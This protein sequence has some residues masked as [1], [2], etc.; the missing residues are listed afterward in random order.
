MKRILLT[1]LLVLAAVPAWAADFGTTIVGRSTA[2]GPYSATDYVPLIRGGVVFKAPTNVFVTTTGIQTLSNKTLSSPVLT[3]PELGTP[4]SGTLTNASGLPLD[5]GVVG[6]LSV[7]NGGTGQTSYSNGEVL[8]GNSSTGGLSKATLTAGANVTITN[9]AGTITI[10]STGGGSGAGC[11]LTGSAGRIVINSG[12]STCVDT[13]IASVTVGALTLGTSGTLGSVTMGNATSGTLKIQPVTGALG[14]ATLSLPAATDTLVGRDTTDTLTN[15]TLTSP[16]INSPT[17]TSPVLGTV[18]SGNLAN[19]TGLPISTG[20]AGLGASVATFLGSA[21]SANL[22]TA[23]SDE[24][25]TGSLYFQSGDLGTP[26]AG[27][28]TNATGLPLTTGVTGTLPV[29]NGGSGQSS[30]TNGQLLIGNTAT[31]LLSKATLTAGTNITITNGN[32][33]ITID[34][35]GGGGSGCSTAGTSGQII[36]DD[37]AGGCTASSNASLSAG[38]LTL[39][40]SGTAGSV[41]MGN[42]TSGLITLQPVTGALGTVTLSLPAATD[43][44]VGRNTSDTLTN[45]VLTSP[46]LTS[47]ALGTPISATLSNATG[48]PISTGVSGLATGIATF[49]GTPSSANLA[50]AVTDETGSG[51]LVF[52]TSPTLVTPALGTPSALILTN[53][54]GLSLTAGVS[55]ILPVAN[56]GTNNAFFTVSGPATSAKTFTFPNASSTVLTSN[57]AVTV[58]QGGTGIASGTSGGIPY[59]S[60]TTTIASSAALTANLPVIGGGAGV[61]PSVG[62]RSGNTTIFVSTTGSQTSGDCVKIDSSGNHVAQGGACGTA[63]TVTDGT[64]SVTTVSTLT[65]GAGHVVSGSSGSATVNKSATFDAQTGNSAYTVVSGDAGKVITRS[66]TVTQTDIVPQATGTF[67]SGFGFGYVTAT[68]GNT[69]TSTT[70]TINGIAGATGI[71]VGAQQATDWVSDGTNWKVALG[72]PQPATQTGTTVLRDDM[73]WATLGTAGAAATGTSGHTLPYLDGANTWSAAQTFGT[74]LGTMT[75]QTGTTYTLAATDCGTTVR[76][77]SGSAITLTTLNSLSVGCAIAV[78]QAGAGQITVTN[79]ASA[80]MHSAHSYTKT[81]GQYGVIGLYVDTNAG[82]SAAHFIVTGDGST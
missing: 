58:A 24:T 65:F 26:S 64:N 57:A 36:T 21:S 39:G 77:S 78:L 4:V 11:T 48:L 75:T 30:Y 23:M 12:S 47:P 55:G 28:L 70:S 6:T 68:V 67:G 13:A 18:A 53:A 34:S 63:Q 54:T 29:A 31:G 10:A 43:T 19:A 82:G 25:G 71:K 8:I 62:T 37:G 81:A 76:F 42:A 2:S 32:G 22:R 14:T 59:F 7:S 72:V 51:A 1:A 49:L 79:G 15:K 9:A 80:T 5:S 56:G 69:M 50:S 41:K 45:K 3:S 38:A 27:T 20:V 52:A 35:S 44:L 73:T 17:L 74:V 60:A 40:A 61:A 46:T 66:D 33:T 16:T